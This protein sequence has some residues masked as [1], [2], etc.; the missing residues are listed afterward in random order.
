MEKKY[1]K[2]WFWNGTIGFALIGAGLSVTIDALALRLDDV[3][4]WVWGAE[5]TAGLVLFMAGLAFFGDAV[6]CR[7]FMDLEAEKP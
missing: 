1:R 2:L 7:V 6:R 3:A 4:W 5:G